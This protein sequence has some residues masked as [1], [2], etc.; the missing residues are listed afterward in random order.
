MAFS[1]NVSVLGGEG[2]EGRGERGE[3]GGG[4]GEVLQASH[5]RICV[6]TFCGSSC[7][8]CSALRKKCL[9]GL[10]ITTASTPAAY[11]RNDDDDDRDC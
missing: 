11:C 2:G 8:C 9:A 6:C 10:P 3:G 1:G 5:S 7:N 4:G